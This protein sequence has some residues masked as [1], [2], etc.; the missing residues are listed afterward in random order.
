M[1]DFDTINAAAQHV[2]EVCE[3]RM[4]AD[5]MRRIKEAYA[6]AFE[7][8]KDQKRNTG[9]PYISHPVAVAAIAAE[10]LELDADTVIAAFLHDVVEDTPYTVEDIRERFGD[11][12]AFLVDVV[13][14]RNKSSYEHTKQVDNYRQI[15]DSVHY[16]IRA[17]LVKLSDRLHNMRTLA[18]M[19]PD[20]QMKIAGETDFFYAPLAGRLGLYH[21]KS[22]L[23]NLSFNF[24]CPREFEA[25]AKLLEEDRLRTAPSLKAFTDEIDAILADS[26]IKARTQIRYRMPYSIWRN[27]KEDKCDFASVKFKHFVR[28]IYTP[29]EGWRE[30]ISAEKDTALFIYSRLS[31]F[32]KESPG[33]VMNYIDCPKDNGYQSF[34]VRLLNR[35]GAWEEMHIASER[36]HRNSKLGCVVER[37]ESWLERFQTVLLNIAESGNG[38]TFMEGVS[39]S[40]YNEDIIAF[41]PKGKGLI[42][43]KG[44]TAL[45]FAFEVHTDIGEHAQYARING[46]LCPVKTE[47]HRGDC[48]EIGTSPNVSPKPEWLEYAKTYK[49]RHHLRD[50]LRYRSKPAFKLCPL[51]SPLPGDE[52]IGFKEDDGTVVLHSRHCAE[53]I[54]LASERGNSIVSVAFEPDDDLTYPVR[55]KIVAIDRYHLLRDIIDCFVER[56]HLSMNA[57]D[58]IT[59]DEIVTCYIDFPV[60]SVSELQ[61]TIENISAIPSV[62]EVQR[63]SLKSEEKKQS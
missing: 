7:A 61:T 21:V 51:C 36:M 45:D 37:G 38:F 56:Q 54:R 15:L 55:I 49:A 29:M 24:R 43:Q 59:E 6:L 32:F 3:K 5:D 4:S 1:Q 14:K 52:V 35:A 39:S 62:D 42:L 53:A 31:S 12:V 9:E 16:D 60:K 13:T 18:G 17:L 57:L 33:S 8:H 41:T 26:G 34:H 22:E 46:V 28:V 25:I 11:G 19:R 27:M 50:M 20:K 48:V 10:E 30:G 63:V 2:F 40:L 44:A 58:T 23:E 47:L